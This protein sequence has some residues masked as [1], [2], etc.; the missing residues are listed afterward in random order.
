[1]RKQRSN[2]GLGCAPPAGVTVEACSHQPAEL[3][4][5]TLFHRVPLRR[6]QD[7]DLWC[8]LAQTLSAT[9]RE[10]SQPWLWL[11]QLHGSLFCKADKCL[12]NRGKKKE[13]GHLHRAPCVQGTAR[14]PGYWTKPNGLPSQALKMM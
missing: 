3:V 4:V 13:E 12:W 8:S 6:T 10:C 2:S 11:P 9:S 5:H 14:V 1:M 7:S